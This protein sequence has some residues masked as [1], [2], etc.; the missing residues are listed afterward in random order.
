MLAQ[1]PI[2]PLEGKQSEYLDDIRVSSTKLLAIINDIIDL[3]TID[4][5]GLELK[6]APVS[7]RDIVETAQSG[8]RD[9]LERARISLDVQIAPNL[10]ELLVDQQRM[11]QILFHLLSNA[12][13]FSPEGS[14]ITL[15]CRSEQDMVAFA[16][17]DSGVGIPEEYHASVFGRFESHSQGSKHRGAGLGLA[18]VKS[19]VDLHGGEIDLRS[20]PGVGTTVTVRVP[21]N[22]SRRNT[23]RSMAAE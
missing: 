20:A 17:Q 19:L 10:D 18:I 1:P 3:A 21:R 7:I 23:E 11:T 8:I 6:I 15:S 5:G 13:G 4:A 12:I 9:R 2:G 22:V 16:V 14:V